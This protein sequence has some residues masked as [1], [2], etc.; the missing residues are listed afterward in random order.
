MSSAAGQFNYVL[1]LASL[2][3]L[4]FIHHETTLET[5]FEQ[6]W[7]GNEI[8]SEQNSPGWLVCLYATVSLVCDE[9]EPRTLTT[10]CFLVTHRYSRSCTMHY[11]MCF[12]TV[13]RWLLF[14]VGLFS[15]CTNCVVLYIHLTYQKLLVKHLECN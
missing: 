8:V 13:A 4:H 2:L 1:L 12:F 6:L 9:P 5:T 14:C 3:S 10:A 15:S 7:S 11:Q